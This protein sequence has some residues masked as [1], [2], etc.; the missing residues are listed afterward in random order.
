M[1]DWKSEQEERLNSLLS[2][3]TD[4]EKKRYKLDFVEKMFPRVYPRIKD[5]D[6]MKVFQNFIDFCVDNIPANKEIP[7]NQKKLLLNK[8][9]RYEH[10]V[11][12]HYKLTYKGFYIAL[13]LAIGVSLGLPIG[14]A[15]GNLALGTPIGM[16]I[17]VGIGSALENKAKKENRIL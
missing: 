1:S 3:Y 12:Q 9:A 15:L 4:K 5:D 7:S 2:N 10:H 14:A 6:E 16:L 8:I 13:F 11:R 17:G